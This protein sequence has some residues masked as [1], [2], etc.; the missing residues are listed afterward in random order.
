MRDRYLTLSLML[1]C[2]VSVAW[3]E[4]S[5]QAR[6]KPPGLNRMEVNIVDPCSRLTL[7]P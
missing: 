2:A 7:E 5:S 1:K 6:A 3:S 4:A